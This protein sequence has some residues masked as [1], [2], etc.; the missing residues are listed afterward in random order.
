MATGEILMIAMSDAVILLVSASVLGSGVY[1]WQ[2]NVALANVQA[3]QVT[4]L[5]QA[6]TSAGQSQANTLTREEVVV[7]R[8]QGGLIGK[9]VNNQSNS[10][11]ITSPGGSEGNIQ[12]GNQIS[13]LAN[14]Q[15]G[16]N[17]SQ[18]VDAPLYGLHIIEPGDTLSALSER[19]GT[20][21]G[22]LQSINSIDGALIRVGQ[23]L[24]YPLP[25]N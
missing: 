2:N 12:A 8:S 5:A 21:V 4:Q 17:D 7:M 6:S 24:H 20:T 16:N 19:F 18:L 25:A 22:S 10:S 9:P 14:D 23:E 15:N 3:T 11:L 13:S 1:R